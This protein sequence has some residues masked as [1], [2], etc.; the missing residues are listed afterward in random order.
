MDE[1]AGRANDHLARADL[2][3]AQLDDYWRAAPLSGQLRPRQR[4]RAACLRLVRRRADRHAAELHRH[5]H[6]WRNGR[7]ARQPAA[8][9]GAMGPPD[10]HQSEARRGG[11]WPQA[12]IDLRGE[13]A[14]WFDRWLKNDEARRRAESPV[15][16]FVMGAN[17][18]RDEQEWP[19]ARTQWT[20]YHLHSGGAA[21]QPLRRWLARARGARVHEPTDS[22]RYDPARPA[23][24]MTEPTSSQIGG[25]DDYA[26]VERRDDVLV[27]MTAAAGGR[28][29]G[30]WGS[31]IGR[32]LRRVLGARYRFHRHADRC[33]AERLRAAALRW[34]RA[35]ALPRGDGRRP[36][37]I[38]PGKSISTPSTAGIRRRSSRRGI[39]SAWRS[40]RARS[41]SSTRNLNTGAPLG[42]T[43]EMAVAEQVIYHD[44]EHPS[45]L[46]LPIIPIVGV[47]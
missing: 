46:I 1:R 5:D 24:F 40:R 30:H 6:A 28:C 43:S 3:H 22:Y 18:W 26:A 29:R 45:A 4:A 13:Q 33:L 20:R 16:I 8:A 42:T 12:L 27:Y 34:H 36:S 37:L 44:A 9:D 7:G 38:E 31:I 10:Q 19:L 17:V 32:S 21:E 2:A 15:R 35:G 41:P 23:P 25:P 47:E 11:L 14:R 39:A